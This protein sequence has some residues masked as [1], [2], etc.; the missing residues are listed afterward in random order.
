VPDAPVQ[1]TSRRSGISRFRIIAATRSPPVGWFMGQDSI[2]FAAIS[3]H[4][5]ISPELVRPVVAALEGIHV[6]AVIATEGLGG[7]RTPRW[8]LPTGV[9]I[10]FRPG[11]LTLQ[12]LQQFSSGGDR[13]VTAALVALYAE[14]DAIRSSAL[15][16][17]GLWP[18]GLEFHKPPRE[19]FRFVLGIGLRSVDVSHA[20]AGLPRTLHA[21]TARLR[22]SR[23]L[24][25]PMAAIYGES[26]RSLAEEPSCELNHL[27]EDPLHEWEIIT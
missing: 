9:T 10:L 26:G 15:L 2:L 24:F 14:I 27:Y 21:A 18:L 19:L 1:R 20:L 25:G 16:P 11:F 3:T 17:A 22:R 8:L 5:Q 4:P 6:D 23:D 13:P 12:L 7:D